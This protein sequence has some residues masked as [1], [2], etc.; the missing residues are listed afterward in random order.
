M[1]ST[2]SRLK[3]GG[4]CVRS[5][6]GQPVERRRYRR[7]PAL[8]LCVSRAT[9]AASWSGPDSLAHRACTT[10]GW[11]RCYPRSARPARERTRVSGRFS[12]GPRG[13]VGL[14]M[15]GQR[16]FLHPAG[17][18]EPSKRQACASSAQHTHSQQRSA[19]KQQAPF[20]S[21]TNYIASLDRRL[22]RAKPH[23]SDESL[24]II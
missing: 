11:F 1:Q 5:S 18:H 23:R 22:R 4:K 3:C 20:F 9:C 13:N 10:C 24:A 15:V 12:G 2:A 14:R 6:S 21:R 7:W 19:T 16:Q 17:R 8:R